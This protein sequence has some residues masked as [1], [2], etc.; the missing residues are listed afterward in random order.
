MVFYFDQQFLQKCE[1]NRVM[2][3]LQACDIIF[4]GLQK[5]A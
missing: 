4:V 2:L 3:Y 1:R 5:A